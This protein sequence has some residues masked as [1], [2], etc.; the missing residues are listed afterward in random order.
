MISIMMN[1]WCRKGIDGFRMDVISMISKTKDMPDGNLKGLY[2][3]YS[4][5]CVHGPKVHEYLQE[6]NREVLILRET[7]TVGLPFAHGCKADHV[8]PLSQE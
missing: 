1:W 5:Y 8:R 3:D 4:P 2:G 6:M 7:V